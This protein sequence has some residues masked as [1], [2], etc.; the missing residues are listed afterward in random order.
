MNYTETYTS[1]GRTCQVVGCPV[2][3]KDPTCP[4][5]RVM[6]TCNNNSNIL[7]FVIPLHDGQV[8]SLPPSG[9]PPTQQVSPAGYMFLCSPHGSH[10]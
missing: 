3:G 8:G 6:T 2:E 9:W 1:V 7:C 10:V 4:T 5:E